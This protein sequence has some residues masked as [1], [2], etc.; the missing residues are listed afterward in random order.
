MEEELEKMNY[1]VLYD[2][3]IELNDFYKLGL[4]F[5]KEIKIKPN[6]T[7][8]TIYSKEKGDIFSKKVSLDSLLKIINSKIDINDI[9]I[10]WRAK[11]NSRWDIGFVYKKDILY[12][13]KRYIIIEYRDDIKK[14][15]D[16]KF[17]QDI[18]REISKYS[19]IYY[20]FSCQ[21]PYQG[22]VSTFYTAIDALCLPL[23]SYED[24]KLWKLELPSLANSGDGKKRYLEGMHRLI[25]P[26]NFITNHH[27]EKIIAGISVKEWIS[28]E[29]LNGKLIQLSENL[30]DWFVEEKELE[31]INIEFIKAGLLISGTLEKKLK[32]LKKLP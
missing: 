21:L 17:I 9:Y 16:I 4:E 15:T 8:Y 26:H 12:P 27:L 14:Y 1:I 32:K 25:Y 2:M 31:R 20:G 11:G 13:E 5:Y 24:T 6:Q 10:E 19:K 3:T 29:E 28:K 23:Y 30:W 7:Y 18:I 22:I